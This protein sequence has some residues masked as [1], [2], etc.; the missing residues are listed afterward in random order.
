M[1]TYVPLI[2]KFVAKAFL[3]HTAIAER[4]GLNASDL[5][6]LQLLGG[7]SLSPRELGEKI[8]LTGAAV[9]TL[10]D[11]LEQAGYA[12]RERGHQDRRR[13]TVH[14]V[15]EK[16]REIDRLYAPQHRRMSRLL[17]RYSDQEF[18]T[19][20]DFLTQATKMLEDAGNP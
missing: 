19:V 17:A 13:V 8:G 3:H 9:T 10:L 5:K 2:Q 4:L 6:A 1:R 16:L 20:V 7:E 14:A 11:R 15:P 12:A 18:R